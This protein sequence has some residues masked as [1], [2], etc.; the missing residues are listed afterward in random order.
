MKA[1]IYVLIAIATG[2][3]IYNIFKIDFEHPLQGDST[4]ALIG[5]LACLCA[6]VLLTILII[7]KRIAQKAK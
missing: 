7:S 5:V 1:F 3:L 2:L 6:I 4:V